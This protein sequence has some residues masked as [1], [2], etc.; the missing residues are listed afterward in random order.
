M[1]FR[2][3]LPDGKSDDGDACLLL[4]MQFVA[5]VCNYDVRK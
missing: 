5:E 3:M 2:R 1:S 4:V